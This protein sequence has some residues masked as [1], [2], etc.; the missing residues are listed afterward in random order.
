VT[1]LLEVDKGEWIFIK[2][3]HN[4]TAYRR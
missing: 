3:S 4:G 2:P 1:I